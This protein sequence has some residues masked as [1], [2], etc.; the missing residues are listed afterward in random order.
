MNLQVEAPTKTPKAGA[1]WVQDRQPGPRPQNGMGVA[2]G[3]R[4]IPDL[5]TPES[6]RAL[7][8][9]KEYTCVGFRGF[10]LRVRGC[11]DN[12]CQ[13]VRKRMLNNLR[14]WSLACVGGSCEEAFRVT[15]SRCVS[16]G[17]LGCYKNRKGLEPQSA[18]YTTRY[19][20][21]VCCRKAL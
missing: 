15:M 20:L 6:T 19:C 9:T 1:V 13:G 17:V 21:L 3:G 7:L 5:W 18:S 16:L 8:I 12:W 11:L 10:G 4:G 2:N 14:T